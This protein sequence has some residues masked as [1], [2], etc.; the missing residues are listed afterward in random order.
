MSPLNPELH[1]AYLA[2][3]YC[4]WLG[5]ADELTLCIGEH[6]SRLATLMQTHGAS[7]GCFVSAWNPFSEARTPEENAAAQQVLE[8]EL[9]QCGWTYFPGE[10]RGTDPAW[11]P[12]ASF[13]VLG[14]DA[15]DAAALCVGYAQ[16]AVVVFDQRAV[17]RLLVGQQ[18]ASRDAHFCNA[19]MLVPKIAIQDP[20]SGQWSFG[21]KGFVLTTPTANAMVA[22]LKRAHRD[23]A[24]EREEVATG[25]DPDPPKPI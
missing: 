9:Q 1:A 20:V 15:D 24:R 22:A 18:F 10:G 5:L 17:P 16:H 11:V 8:A 23:K 14:P 21:W 6:N 19:R 4:A 7:S 3:R 13:L 25:T 12:E 2:T